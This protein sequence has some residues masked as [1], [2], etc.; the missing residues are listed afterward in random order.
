MD[1]Q[2]SAKNLEKNWLNWSDQTKFIKKHKE[3]L[4]KVVWPW[5]SAIGWNISQSVWNCRQTSF[6]VL[7][8]FFNEFNLIRPV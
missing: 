2:K 8:W 5:I 4:V 1:K 6:T 3:K 7:F